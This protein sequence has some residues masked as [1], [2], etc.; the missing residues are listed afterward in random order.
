MERLRGGPDM[1][2][3]ESGSTTAKLYE[4]NVSGYEIMYEQIG[5]FFIFNVSLLL[6]LT[7]S[8]LIYKKGSRFDLLV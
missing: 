4:F 1:R 6:S 7:P 5:L 3:A 2:R 8:K